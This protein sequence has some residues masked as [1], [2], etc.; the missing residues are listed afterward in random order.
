MPRCTLCSVWIPL[1][2]NWAFLIS[3]RF[4]WKRWINVLKIVCE[5]DL[6]VNMDKLF[7]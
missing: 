4:S 7:P 1:K 6:I 2:M 3:F 5:L